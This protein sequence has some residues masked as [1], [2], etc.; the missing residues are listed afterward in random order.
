MRGFSRFLHLPVGLSAVCVYSLGRAASFAVFALCRLC[1][2]PLRALPT[3]A[4]C[5]RY[6]PVLPSNLRILR[7]APYGP[8]L[9]AGPHSH[10][11]RGFFCSA[12]IFCPS[13]VSLPSARGLAPFLR[14]P[15]PMSWVFPFGTL[16]L[17]LVDFQFL[18]PMRFLGWSPSLAWSPPLAAVQS[19]AFSKHTGP[20]LFFRLCA[21][22]GPPQLIPYL[23]APL[24]SAVLGASAP[25]FDTAT[26]VTF[27][28]TS[29]ASAFVMALVPPCTLP[30]SHVRFA[31]HAFLP[32]HSAILHSVALI[33]VF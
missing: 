16:R 31:S 17:Y 30:F 18:P 4:L 7:S 20:R 22:F 2:G 19:G 14:Y 23:A 24:W 28:L 6:T 5:Y 9:N 8:A 15:G 26:L 10:F 3:A 13:G 25:R 27:P 33:N 32:F 21:R 1:N 29:F 11:T 12:I